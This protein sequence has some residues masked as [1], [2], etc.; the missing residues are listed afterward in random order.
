LTWCA[1]YPRVR[2]GTLAEN[3][4]FAAGNNR[5]FEQA[6]GNDLVTLNKTCIDGNNYADR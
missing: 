1:F 5:G 6:R 3:T 4:G 2:L